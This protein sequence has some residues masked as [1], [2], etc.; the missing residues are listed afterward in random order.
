MYTRCRVVY[1]RGGVVYTSGGVVYTRGEVAY[2][3]G[4]VFTGTNIHQSCKRFIRLFFKMSLFKIYH[5]VQSNTVT[6]TIALIM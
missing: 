5:K 4:G 1:T 2:T 6:L 3:R